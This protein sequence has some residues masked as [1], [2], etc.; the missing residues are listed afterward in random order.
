ML[1][2]AALLHTLYDAFSGDRIAFLYSGSFHDTHTPRLIALGEE[3][4]GDDEDGRTVRGRVVF[5]LVEAYQNIVRHRAMPPPEVAQKAGRSLFL[6]RDGGQRHEVTTMNPV[7]EADARAIHDRLD[8]LHGLDQEELKARFIQSLQRGARTERG[9]AGLGFIEMARRSGDP[10]HHDMAD[11]HAGYKLFTLQVTLGRPG[12]PRTRQEVLQW[13][14]KT[15]S[16]ADLLLAFKGPVHQGMHEVL[17]RMMEEE[18]AENTGRPVRPGEAL[19]TILDRLT[20]S[21]AE[22]GE[23]LVAL[24]RTDGRYSVAG[25][26]PVL[27]SNGRTPVLAAPPGTRSQILPHGTDGRFVFVEIAL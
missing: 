25:G 19:R 11:I 14:H 23:R 9:G 15:T 6:L 2:D 5:V 13:L 4:V 21:G 8:G 18:L 22:A 3:A 27:S 10:L 16:E 12:M 1:M 7:T 17:V 26:A 20:T 24:L